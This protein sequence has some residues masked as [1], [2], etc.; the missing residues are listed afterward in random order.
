MHLQTE[1]CQALRAIARPTGLTLSKANPTNTAQ[2]SK[3]RNPSNATTKNPI[4]LKMDETQAAARSA[5]AA[6]SFITA[7]TR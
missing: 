1:S 4:T 5:D 6:D 7:A 2:R 3:K